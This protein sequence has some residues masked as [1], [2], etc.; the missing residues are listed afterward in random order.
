[1][2][3]F[4][5]VFFFAVTGLTLNHPQWFANQMRTTKANG[6]LEAS[7]THTAADGDVKKL[8]IVELLRNRH[9]IHAA[10]ADFRVDD[11]ECDLNFKGPGY[12]AEAVIDR[13]SGHYE[14]TEARMGWGAIINDLHKGRDTGSGWKALIDVSA[15]LLV[16]VIADRACPDLVRPQTPRGGTP[17]PCSRR[18]ALVPGLHDLGAVIGR[19]RSCMLP[20]NH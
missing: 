14:L 2:S 16:F 7:W 19:R 17:L 6:S 11:R 5:I 15:I 4:A 9:G 13:A 8:E 3:S 18:C 20:A 1:M 12:S 10:L